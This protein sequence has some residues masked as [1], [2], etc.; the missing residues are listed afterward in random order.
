MILVKESFEQFLLEKNI[1][2]VATLINA[3]DAAGFSAELDKSFKPEVNSKTFDASI[4]LII[5]D[6]T[7]D[8]Y[9]SI[10]ILSG[11]VYWANLSKNI[12]LGEITDEKGLVKNIRRV[13]K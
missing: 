5:N 4:D 12:K 13:F 8:E 6:K 2:I 10:N 7:R 3:F 11:V 1:D 9:V